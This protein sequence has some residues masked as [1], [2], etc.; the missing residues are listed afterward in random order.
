MNRK[1]HPPTGTD[2]VCKNWEIEAAYRM[3]QHNLDP[4]VAE[5]PDELIVYGGKGKAARNWES[6]DSI[7]ETLKR[8]EPDETLLIQS[9]KPVGVARTHVYSP[10][11]LIA[12][13]NLVPKW[14]N[15]EHFNS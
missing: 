2:L 14:A 3:I 6:F 9:G 15:W 13:S 12:N 4:D 10:R 8:L 11:V 1:I 7:L 5:L